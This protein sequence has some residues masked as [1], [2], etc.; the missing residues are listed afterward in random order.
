MAAMHTKERNRTD[1]EGGGFIGQPTH[2]P[3][4]KKRVSCQPPNASS[5][6]LSGHFSIPLFL[7]FFFAAA[8]PRLCVGFLL[9]SGLEGK[10]FWA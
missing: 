4:K 1:E 2:A 5:F 10:D 6:S 7:F 8:A 3:P 9:R